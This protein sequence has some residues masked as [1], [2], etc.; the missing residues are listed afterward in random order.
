MSNELCMKPDCISSHQAEGG[1]LYV[2]DKLE[3]K[4]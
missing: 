1:I 2:V 4:K 3:E